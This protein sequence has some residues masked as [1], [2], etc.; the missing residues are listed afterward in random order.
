MRSALAASLSRV[1]APGVDD[2]LV[3]TLGETAAVPSE[4]LIPILVARH[5]VEAV[6][7]VQESRD[8]IEHEGL[9]QLGK[10]V[11]QEGNAHARAYAMAGGRPSVCWSRRT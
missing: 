6:P 10:C 11:E 8:L 5:A 2:L 1:A 4:E 3:Q 7:A 9:G